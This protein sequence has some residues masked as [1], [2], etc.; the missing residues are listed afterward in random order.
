MERM[1]GPHILKGDLSAGYTLGLA[2]KDV[3]LACQLGSDS[4][5]PLFLGN[6][7]RE[8]Y[9]MYL[10]ELGAGAKVD[11]TALIIDRTAGTKIVPDD[12]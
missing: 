8:L 7:T 1:L 9:Q 6:L 4:G 5:V 2:H 11:M 3:R 12:Q 10:N